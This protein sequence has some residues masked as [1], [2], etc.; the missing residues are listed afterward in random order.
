MP[1]MNAT[2]RGRAFVRRVGAPYPTTAGTAVTVARLS[3]FGRCMGTGPH[4]Y[5]DWTTARP[6]ASVARSN[7]SSCQFAPIDHGGGIDLAG[8]DHLV[9]LDVLVD[10]VRHHHIAS[11]E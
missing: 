11:A 4:A 8:V 10:R 2:L 1:V 6:R 5:D 3:I 7:A 9:A